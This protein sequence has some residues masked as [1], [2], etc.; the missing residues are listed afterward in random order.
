MNA[1]PSELIKTT[2]MHTLHG[3]VV[4]YVTYFNRAVEENSSRQTVT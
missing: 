4:Y 2:E 3:W 1:E